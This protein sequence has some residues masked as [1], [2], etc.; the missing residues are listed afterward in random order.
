MA[1]SFPPLVSS[2][3]MLSGVSEHSSALHVAAVTAKASVWD[4]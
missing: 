4:D 2:A 3:S 1:L